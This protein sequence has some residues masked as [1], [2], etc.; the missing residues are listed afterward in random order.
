MA[1]TS[2]ADLVRNATPSGGF[3]PVPVGEYDAVVSGAE[4]KTSSNGNPMYN[5]EF[6]ITDSGEAKGRKAWRN[7]TITER[8]VGMAL[9]QLIALGTSQEAVAESLI[10][11]NDLGKATVCADLVDTPCRIK[12]KHREYNGKTQSDVDRIMPA[13]PGAANPLTATTLS[14][15]GASTPAASGAARPS[16]PF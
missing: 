12:I 7:I 15:Q 10:E 16:T 5:V 6:T 14:T 3:S 8:S 4:F 9:D 13:G 1:Q 2:F 11:G